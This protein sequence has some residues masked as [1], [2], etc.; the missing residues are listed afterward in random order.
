MKGQPKGSHLQLRSYFGSS[1]LQIMFK[2]LDVCAPLVLPGW[3]RE[4]QPCCNIA[5]E[6]QD[7]LTQIF[8]LLQVIAA[9]QA[10]LVLII[11]FSC[12][13]T[14]RGLPVEPSVIQTHPAGSPRVHSK[15]F[16]S[17]AAPGGSA[18]SHSSSRCPRS[19]RRADAC[20][21]VTASDFVFRR[22]FSRA[23]ASTQ[24]P[25]ASGPSRLA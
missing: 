15:V 1:T 9:V 11:V 18:R 3:T 19:V 6:L 13:R 23:D 21:E 14:R 5:D 8:L 24:T 25:H 12:I 22:S 10:I 4:Q 16:V 20:I 7:Q 2:L 17:A